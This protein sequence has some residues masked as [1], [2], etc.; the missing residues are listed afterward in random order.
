MAAEAPTPHPRWCSSSAGKEHETRCS[1]VAR[2]GRERDKGVLQ[3]AGKTA[4]GRKEVVA[5]KVLGCRGKQATWVNRCYTHLW[6]TGPTLRERSSKD[7]EAYHD[8][9]EQSQGRGNSRRSPD[10]RERNCRREISGCCDEDDEVA[11]GKCR[12]TELIAGGRSCGTAF[13]GF[14]FSLWFSRRRRRKKEAVPL[15]KSRSMHGFMGKYSQPLPS[16]WFWHN[17][18]LT[19]KLTYNS[20]LAIV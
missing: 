1:S 4:H 10:P 7:G 6:S 9:K 18:S 20:L 3:V 19:L 12:R 15:L 2:L 8:R 11:I 14:L 5:G 16:S 13:L 17:N